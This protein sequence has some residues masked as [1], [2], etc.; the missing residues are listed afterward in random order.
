MTRIVFQS[1]VRAKCLYHPIVMTMPTH[2][3]TCFFRFLSF[4]RSFQLSPSPTT[5]SHSKIS[6]FSSFYLS[7]ALSVSTPTV[8]A[9]L[10]IYYGPD[11]QSL[12]RAK[13][14]Y[15]PGEDAHDHHILLAFNRS[16]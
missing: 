13:C 5:T 3:T 11:F 4:T 12:V 15:H 7:S 8:H 6:I 10:P 16:F 9:A 2:I 1:L 14:L